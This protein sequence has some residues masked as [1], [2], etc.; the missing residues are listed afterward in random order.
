MP[1]SGVP[2]DFTGVVEYTVSGEGMKSRTYTVIVQKD[3]S[4]TD[5]GTSGQAERLWEKML[6]DSDADLNDRNGEAWWEKAE[7]SRKDN[8]YPEYW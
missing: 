2:Q 6:E 8:D 5:A 7:R 4:S 1:L 3:G